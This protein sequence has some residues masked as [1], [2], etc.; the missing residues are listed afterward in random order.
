MPKPSLR[1]LRRRKP[2]IQETKLSMVSEVVQ[3]YE[4]T[5]IL[6]PHGS[7]GLISSRPGPDLGLLGRSIFRQ[8]LMILTRIWEYL[9]RACLSHSAARLMALSDESRELTRFTTLS[10]MPGR[11]TNTVAGTWYRHHLI[12]PVPVKANS[13]AWFARAAICK[14]DDLWG[15]IKLVEVQSARLQATQEEAQAEALNLACKWIDHTLDSVTL[16]R[17]QSN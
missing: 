3:P 17:P 8:A 5:W 7:I 4:S 9:A 10:E 14:E 15:T 1:G 2:D 11:E 12:R 6:S 13:R 16:S